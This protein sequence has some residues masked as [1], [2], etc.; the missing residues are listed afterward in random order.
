MRNVLKNNRGMTLVEIMIV[1]AII[2]GLVALLAP[3]FMGQQQKAKAQEAKIEMGQIMNALNLYFTDCGSFPET[4]KSL[5]EAPGD[6]ECPNWGPEPYMKSAPTDPWN[7]EYVY[8]VDGSSY[9]VIS[10]GADRREGGSG[11]D[12]DISTEDL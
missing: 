9:E 12:K 8:T 6:G 1:L 10:L 7:N 2:G 4:L 3:R 5:S 11:Y